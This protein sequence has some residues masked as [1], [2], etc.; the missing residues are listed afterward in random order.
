MSK[1]AKIQVQDYTGNWVTVGTTLMSDQIIF[2]AVTSAKRTY[3]GKLV[4][5]IDPLGNILQL[6]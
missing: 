5:A 2:R 3:K 6:Q 1:L 4:R